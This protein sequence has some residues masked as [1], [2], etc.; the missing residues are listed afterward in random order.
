MNIR[1]LIPYFAVL[2]VT[3]A[4]T[5]ELVYEPG[6]EATKPDTPVTT[7]SA[8]VTLTGAGTLQ[9]QLEAIE[10]IDPMRLSALKVKGDING[11][12]LK[13]LRTLAGSG[14]TK[15]EKSTGQLV[16]LDLSE[17]RF[18]RGGE[19]HFI[20]QGNDGDV[21][22]TLQDNNVIP[23]YAFGYTKLREV[24]LPEGI[25]GLGLQAFYHC[26]S[27]R[28]VNIP[29]TV[30][31]IGMSAFCYCAKLES[32]LTVPEGVETLDHYTFDTCNSLPSI[33]LPKSLKHIGYMCFSDCWMIKD[34]GGKLP[35]LE[36]IEEYAFYNCV[37][38]TQ[39]VVPKSGILPEGVYYKCIDLGVPNLEGVREIGKYAFMG[40]M[41][42]GELTLPEG[43]ETIADSAF[44]SSEVQGKLVGPS[45]LKYI[46]S[47]T[48]ASNAI[49]DLIL[50]S[51]VHTN[52][53]GRAAFNSCKQLKSLTLTEG[54]R[55][56]DVEFANCTALG[57]VSLPSTLDSIGMSYQYSSAAGQVYTSTNG[58]IFYNCSGLTAIELPASLR[59]IGASSFSGCTKL[60][61]VKLPDAIEWTG[62]YVFKGCSSLKTLTLPNQ[63]T[64]VAQGLCEECTALEYIELPETMQLIDYAAFKGSGI[65]EIHL[66][67]NV[68][69]V[70]P[71]AFQNCEKLTAINLPKSLQ[72]IDR[73]A[74]N[75][76][77][78][79]DNITYEPD[80]QL[81]A[82]GSTAFNKCSSLRS[83]TI[84]PAVSDVGQYAFSNSGLMSV[85]IPASVSTIGDGAF[86][87]CG[88]LASV[89]NEAA[90]PQAINANVFT[91]VT[92]SAAT[93]SVQ[94]QAVNAYKQAAVWGKFGTI[95][96]LP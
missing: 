94:A 40:N 12:D 19:P 13:Y 54:C 22:C 77:I 67:D 96:A 50:Q 71:M 87:H 28:S 83:F 79:L 35:N 32:P 7:D 39:M 57:K 89:T 58:S 86:D 5:K 31:T 47:G 75:G 4:C 85:D 74:F 17:S 73:D 11:S 15:G 66:P 51:D 60:T 56:L 18:V 48:F 30:R 27:L 43:L 61:E 10:G 69:K 53:D 55:V 2:L 25:T 82:I 80:C 37:Y 3:L 29:S 62:A 1:H 45:T 52:H 20:Y 84:P 42:R 76:C 63:L 21:P 68:T 90:T 6:G 72:L 23:R 36:T 44:Y 64:E 49:T 41:I 70:G 33:K 26:D 46:G 59:F 9:A 93:L 92:L 16:R 38:L 88:R 34:F 78:S 8:S 95:T 24:L 65:K 91:G 81:S 14:L